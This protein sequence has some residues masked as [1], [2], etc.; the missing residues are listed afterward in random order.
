MQNSRLTHGIRPSPKLSPILT[1]RS[2]RRFLHHIRHETKPYNVAVIGGGLTG[3]TAAWRLLQDPKCQKITLYE[4]S[5]QLGG[6][7]QSERIEVGDGKHVVFEHGPRTIRASQ[8]AVMPMLDL[9]FSLDLSEQIVLI[10][11]TSPAARNRY[12]Y[13]PDH[14][15]RMPGPKPGGGT[16][17][18][19]LETLTTIFT[20]PIFKGTVMGILKEP[21][22]ETRSISDLRKDESVGDFISRRF[23][24]KVADN[25]ASAVYHGIY[26]GDIYKLS[27]DT[28]LGPQRLHEAQHESVIIGAMEMMQQKKKII[29]ADHLLAM[30]SVVG[31]RP[32]NHF[33]RLGV[34]VGPASVFTIKDGLAEIARAFERGFKKHSEKIEVVTDARINDIKREDNHDITISLKDGNN[35]RSQTF[36]RVISTAPPTEMARL[37][38]AGSEHDSE[39]PIESISRLKAQNYAVNV[40]VVNLFYDD[41]NLVPYRGFGYLIPRNVPFEQNP[42]RGLGV[43]FSSETSEHQDTAVGTKLTVMMGG[44]WWDGWTESDLPGPEKATEMARSLLKRHLGI[45]AT[46]VVTRARLQRDAIPQYTVN[47]LVKMGGLSDAIRKDFDRRLTLAGNWYGTHGVGVND[48]VVQGYLAAAWGVD[49]IEGIKDFPVG[50]PTDL[51]DEQA[52][53]IP[54]STK[55]YLGQQAH[56]VQD[57]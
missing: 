22:V 1:A 34:L 39:K 24:S 14:L 27:A 51:M 46:P 41:P 44:H 26:A 29:P 9:L 15:V 52:G 35:T 21:A 32:M 40:M 37:I 47:H 20:E 57:K 4:K 30:F 53:G 56:R 31:Q 50:M 12:V 42:E 23:G 13:Y 54:T 33:D 43:I 38:E 7:L 36:N 8:P 3:L 5:S 28:I 18:T 19:I 25:L 45:D 16:L 17:S 55:R 49:S 10:G 6:W 2:Q 48:C 11:K